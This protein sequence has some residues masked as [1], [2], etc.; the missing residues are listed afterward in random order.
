MVI[1][2]LVHLTNYLEVC[3]IRHTIVRGKKKIL[4]ASLKDKGVQAVP[5]FR[6]IKFKAARWKLPFAIN[7]I[8]F[9]YFFLIFKI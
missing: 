4:F 1:H 2:Y 7:Y 5:L 9:M 3:I 6:K 8:K